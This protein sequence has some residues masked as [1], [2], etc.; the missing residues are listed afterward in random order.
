MPS[1]DAVSISSSQSMKAPARM[2]PSSVP[3]RSQKVTPSSSNTPFTSRRRSAAFS[4][5][6]GV[7][8]RTVSM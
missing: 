1:T 3:E 5:S 2:M 4:L 8:D 7:G 6:S